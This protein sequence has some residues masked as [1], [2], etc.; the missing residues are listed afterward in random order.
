MNGNHLLI[1]LQYCVKG[2]PRSMITKHDAIFTSNER[3]NIE[4]SMFR[5]CECEG[6]IGKLSNMNLFRLTWYNNFIVI[7]N[8]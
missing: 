1:E 2:N 6:C 3:Y 8:I 5:K 4:M 7:V